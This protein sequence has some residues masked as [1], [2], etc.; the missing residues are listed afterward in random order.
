MAALAKD[1]A[2]RWQSADD[3]AEALQAAGA[4]LEHGATAQ[5]TAAFA[6]VPAPRRCRRRAVPPPPTLT[7]AAARART[8]AGLFTVGL[9][10]RRAGRL[11]DLPRRGGADR[12]RDEGGAARGRQA[13]AAGPR[14]SSSAPASR[15]RSRA[16]AARRRSTRSSTRTRTRAR[17]PTRARR[18][19]S[20]SRAGPGTVRVPTVRGLPPG[21]AIE[22]LEQ[23][24]PQGDRRPQAVRDASR[25]ASRSAPSRRPAS[26]STAASACSC[27]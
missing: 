24:R 5:D 15:W 20:R 1:P 3:F 10:T 17:R 16:C 21:R 23:A 26:R 11:P 22:A 13:A 9:L 6:P 12:R 18:W 19:C 8:G 7:R 4:Q 14:R 25:R 2:H 27:S